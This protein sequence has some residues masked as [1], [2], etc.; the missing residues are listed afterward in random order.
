MK[1]L[2]CIVDKI[3]FVYRQENLKIGKDIIRIYNL[4]KFINKLYSKNVF[5]QILHFMKSIFKLKPQY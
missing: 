4:M 3:F 1:K 2:F 5:K